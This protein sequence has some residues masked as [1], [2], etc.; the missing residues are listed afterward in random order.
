MPGALGEPDVAIK[1]TESPSFVIYA[2]VEMYFMHLFVQSVN[3]PNYVQPTGPALLR[4]LTQHMDATPYKGAWRKLICNDRAVQRTSELRS[5]ALSTR[6]GKQPVG[7]SRTQPPTGCTHAVDS[8][9]ELYSFYRWQMRHHPRFDGTGKQ[10]PYRF[11]HTCTHLEVGTGT[12]LAHKWAL[13][14]HDC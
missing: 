13:D 5:P 10:V 2:V 6:T 7:A 12:A 8:I 11:L 9:R 4:Q 14:Q 3:N 1:E